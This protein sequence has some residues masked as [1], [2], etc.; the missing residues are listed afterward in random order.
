MASHT[1]G[2]RRFGLGAETARDFERSSQFL[3]AA[4]IEPDQREAGG[5]RIRR[6]IEVQDI[7]IAAIPAAV[8]AAPAEEQVLA[9]AHAVF[10]LRA[11]IIPCDL[12]QR[13]QACGRS[14]RSRMNCRRATASPRA[15][16]PAWSS[17]CAAGMPRAWP[18]CVPRRPRC[19]SQSTARLMFESQTPRTEASVTACAVTQVP[20]SIPAPGRVLPSG[21]CQ[22]RTRRQARSSAASDPGVPCSASMA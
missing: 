11:A 2:E 12:L 3:R 10:E 15:R 16:H 19:S 22:D 18:R 6:Q 17:A 9:L 20:P 13:H 4:P 14:A 21:S 8:A 5:F 7:R 1:R